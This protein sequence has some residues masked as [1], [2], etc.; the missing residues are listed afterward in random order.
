MVRNRPSFGAYLLCL[1]FPPGY[2]FSRKRK[3][4]GIFSLIMLLVSI[5]LMF[6]VIGFFVWFANAI[7]AAWSLRYELMDVHVNEQARAIA[8]EMAA[9]TKEQL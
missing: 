4:A 6:F 7:W 5:P 9:Q 1:F 8:R 3:G 2:F